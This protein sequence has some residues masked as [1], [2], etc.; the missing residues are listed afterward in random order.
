MIGYSFEEFYALLPALYRIRD[1]EQRRQL[2]GLMRVL[3]EQ[4]DVLDQDIAR[5]YDDWFIET[6]QEWVVPYIGDLLRVRGNYAVTP[7]VFSE[8]GYVANTLGYRRRKGTVAVLERLSYDVTGWRTRAVEFFHLLALTQHLNHPHSLSQTPN[9]RDTAT[10]E[11]IGGPFEQSAHNAEVRHI[12]TGRGRYDIPDVGLF[13]WRLQAYPVTAGTAR[14]L[15]EPSDGR[16]HFSP[17]GLDE[18]LFN[19]SRTEAAL[20]HLVEEVDV[21]GQLRRRPLHDELDE[22]RAGAIAANDLDYFAPGE[23]VF[24]VMIAGGPGQP[25]VVIPPERVFICDLSDWR[26]PAASAQPTVAVDPALG[27]IAFP[28]ASTPSEVRV[29]FAYGFSGDIGGGPYDRPLIDQTWLD[30]A[31]TWQMGVVQDQ[32]VRAGAA[33]PQLLVANLTDAVAAW[34][35]QVATAPT[36]FGVIA[37]MDSCTYKED[38]VGAAAPQVPAGSKLAI[39]AAGWPEVSVQ[40]QLGKHRLPGDLVAAPLR[41]HLRGNL[42][43]VGTAASQ[44]P[45]GELVVAGMLLEGRLRVAAGNLGR[46]QVN[47]STLVPGG[48][49]LE[50]ISA[51]NQTNAE[52]NVILESC[53]IGPI[54]L[55]DTV[56]AL[57]VANSVIDAAG[58]AAITAPG[59]EVT[60]RACT[61]F[62]TASVRSLTASDVIFTGS[63][64][65]TR[66][67][68]GCVRFCYVPDGSSVP[69][70]FRCQPDLALTGILDPSLETLIKARLNPEFTSI[71]YGDP[72]Y[73][74]LA[75]ICA[76]E[77]REGAED[78]AEMGAFQFLKQPQRLQNLALGLDEYLRFGLE[79]G[80]HFVT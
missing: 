67:Q 62:G 80:T 51:P 2:E 79:A 52:L 57:S 24:Q 36:A 5:L 64:T 16:L 12:E 7:N 9:L 22:L 61:L 63:A 47:H 21:P 11:L 35:A 60:L 74:Q 69:P 78:G 38:L 25:G 6:C 45:G 3:F 48:G 72:G 71:S 75:T 20:D 41:P 59:A 15:T 13:L 55:P 4:A 33:D 31:V 77:I 42:E 18:P 44:A 73:A 58:A 1:A 76:V 54:A 8:R 17:L 28:V 43:A 27:R 30:R 50:V 34:N 46:L 40:N 10:L 53:V 29:D 19:P 26:R 70:R 14:S 66:L 68:T 32:A 56:P 37:V 65:S 39:V 49:G 23:E